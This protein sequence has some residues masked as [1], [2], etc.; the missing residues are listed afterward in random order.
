[1]FSAFNGHW[2]NRIK[3]DPQPHL[4]GDAFLAPVMTEG[5]VISYISFNGDR[6]R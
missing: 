5:Q 6:S 3:G 2:A 1:M 4:D